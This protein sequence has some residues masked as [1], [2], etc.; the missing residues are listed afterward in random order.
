MNVKS[1]NRQSTQLTRVILSLLVLGIFFATPGYSQDSPLK[2][3]KVERI[4]VHGKGLEGN[5]AGD[6]PDR[7][8][9]VYL[10]PSYQ[11]DKKRRYPVIYFLHGFTD[12]DDKW[13]GFTKHWINLPAVVD[14]TLADGKSGEFILVTPNAYNRYF[15]SMYSN[16]VTIGNWED[17]V[18]DELVAYVDKQYRTL[19]QAASR[20]LAGHSMG[21]YG[22]IRIGQKHP[23]IFSSLYLLSPC[24]MV[25][26]M[27]G[28]A[29]PQMA[30]RMESVKTQA[31]LEKA[32]FGTK[33]M[34]ASAA[35]WS[36]NPTNAPFFLDLPVKGGEPQPMV[37]AK[38][39]ANAPLATLDQYI[40]NIKQ[41]HALAFDAGSKDA[42]IAA[43]NKI[44]D[45]MLTNYSIPH[46][47]EEY[48]GDHINRIGERIEQKMLPF[49]TKNLSTEMAKGGKK[50]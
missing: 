31:D 13:Y 3:G 27:G 43:N 48:D 17:F 38:W 36:P 32:D 33:A 23:E 25:P 50:K 20:G 21:G 49:F 24:C 40:N 28:S 16:S 44:L 39:A 19:P 29:N 5:L 26:N 35:S 9:S 34:F 47:Y 22:T 8:V 41:L 37:T 42:S 7:D 46:T 30:T 18:A 10:P 2:A 14:K 12:S 4:K 6:S 45:A 1:M 11:T 15:G